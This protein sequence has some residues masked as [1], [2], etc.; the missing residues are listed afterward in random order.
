M[1]PGSD[2]TDAGDNSRQREH[3]RVVDERHRYRYDGGQREDEREH[4]RVL[5]RRDGGDVHEQRDH[6]QM[7]PEVRSPAP[8]DETGCGEGDRQAEDRAAPTTLVPPF[9]GSAL[10]RIDIADRDRQPC[11]IEPGRRNSAS[12][13][14]SAPPVTAAR[15]MLLCSVSAHIT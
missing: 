13:A 10:Q 15:L 2:C 9:P 5:N 11:G 14:T 4:A 7:Q 6:V 12:V 8:H 1:L 3:R